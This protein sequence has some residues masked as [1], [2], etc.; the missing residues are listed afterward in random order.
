MNKIIV[1]VCGLLLIVGSARLAQLGW[2]F[3]VM[4]IVGSIL[5]LA[6]GLTMLAPS[7]G[8]KGKDSH[9]PAG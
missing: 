2:S 4:W 8:E 9:E 3:P 7:K 1:F 6:S 5:A